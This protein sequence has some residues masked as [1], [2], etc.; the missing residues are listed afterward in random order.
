MLRPP[1]IARG[2]CCRC[3]PANALARALLLAAWAAAACAAPAAAA[4]EEGYALLGPLRERDMTPYHLTRLEMMPVESAAALA[5][6]WTIETDLTH[7]SNFERSPAV[8]S[9]LALR[10]GRKPLTQRDV[11]AILAVRGDTFFLDGEIGLFALTVHY[12]VDRR[13]GFFLTLPVYYMTG[14]IFDPAIEGYH[15]TFGFPQGGRNLVTRNEFRIVYRVGR[16]QVI[17]IGAPGSGV[18]DPI[19]GVRYRLLPPGGPW[20]VIAESAVKVATRDRGALSTGGT[21]AGVQLALHRAF[22]R[23]AVY[24]DLAVVRVGGPLPDPRV[25]RRMIPA[26]VLA[27]EVGIGHRIS[28]I[29]QYYLSTSVF[30]R[31]NVPDLT[32][33]K[34][35]I[36]GGFRFQHGPVS[37]YFDL[38]E[39]LLHYEN[40]PD[41][42]AQVGMTWK[43]DGQHSRKL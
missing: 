17:E 7:T 2:R 40:T 28:F 32:Q 6:G 9:Y 42:G 39:N 10:G 38:I 16:E 8:A 25:D 26:G 30:K 43:L 27:Y 12:Q 29:L 3:L 37:W 36:V 33:N 11:N 19:L 21:D 24:L 1:T 23:Q 35:E 41:V 34:N 22:R 15:S 18:S 4:G 5:D 20:D 31:S 14:G 13:L